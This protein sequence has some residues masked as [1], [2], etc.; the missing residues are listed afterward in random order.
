MKKIIAL[1]LSASALFAGGYKIPEQ[2]LNTMA[3]GGAYTA[4]ATHADTAYFNPANMSFMANKNFLEGGITLAHLPANKFQGNQALSATVLLPANNESEVEN[5]PIPFFHYVSPAYGDF[6]FGLSLTVP[7][8][9]TK[10]WNS[11]VQKLFA[12]E[13][14]LKIVE[15]NPSFSYKINEQL[16]IGAGVRLIYSEGVVKSNGDEVATPIAR[17]ME[18]DTLEFGYNLALSYQPS[19]SLRFGVTYRSEIELK[20]EGTATLTLNGLTATHDADVTVPLPASLNIAVAADVTDN[21]TVEFN[22]ERTFWSAYETLDFNYGTPIFAMLV[23][24]FDDPKARNWEDTNSYRLGA[25]WQYSD[26]LTL[27]FGYSYDETPAPITTLS[28]ELPDSDAHS[29]STGFRM[30][31]NESLS[32]G[33]AI[34]YSNKKGVTLGAGENDGGIIG[35]FSEG[36]AILTTV[37]VSYVF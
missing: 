8:G 26:D 3:L 19:D 14:S 11:G 6:R 32:W 24:S 29:F 1:S 18:G 21:L 10:R 31:H 2:S 30:K 25:T 7:G 17:E 34:L 12:E 13:F 36:G 4:N 16:S 9:L 15:L 27:M 37:G 20:E 28:Y 33:A 5:I 35:E 23:P 22:Y